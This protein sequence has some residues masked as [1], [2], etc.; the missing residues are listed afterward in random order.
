M[1]TKIVREESPPKGPLTRAQ[2]IQMKGKN[3]LILDK[4]MEEEL[5]KTMNLFDSY[6]TEM[7]RAEKIDD[8]AEKAAIKYER[9]KDKIEV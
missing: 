8:I 6:V 4:A 9:E 2:K 3:Q 5:V 7:G 1:P